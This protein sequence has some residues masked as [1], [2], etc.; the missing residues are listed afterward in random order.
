MFEPSTQG[1]PKLFRAA[2]AE[3]HVV[4][5]SQERLV[6]FERHLFPYDAVL[7][8]VT[9]GAAG[10]DYRFAGEPWR[11]LSA[12]EVDSLDAGGAGDWL[13]AAFLA[14]LTQ[15]NP[16]GLRSR[17]VRQALRDAQ[18]VAAA[19]CRWPGARGIADAGT[20]REILSE[21]GIVA[22]RPR[23]GKLKRAHTPVSSSACRSCLAASA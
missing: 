10:L 20:A 5:Y 7:T 16:T 12:V 21:A 14:R 3:A 2:L 6:R 4:K 13:T 19:S 17:D 23:Q 8:I 22:E 18:A 15:L 1:H 11:A 9:S